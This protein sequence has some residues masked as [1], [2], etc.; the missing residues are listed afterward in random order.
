[1]E[2]SAPMQFGDQRLP[3][4]FWDKTQPEYNSGCW[5]W[6]GEQTRQGYGRFR[7]RRSHRLALEAALGRPLGELWALHS[8]DNPTCVNPAHLRP[9]TPADNCDDMWER[10]RQGGVSGRNHAKSHCAYGH[11]FTPENTRTTGGGLWRQCRECQRRQ[12]RENNPKWRERRRQALGKTKRPNKLPNHCYRGH[13][14]TPENTIRA[15]KARTCR[16]CA[17]VRDSAKQ[18]RYAAA[19]RAAKNQEQDHVQH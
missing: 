10:D 3:A 1:M 14:Y 17:A 5:L 7:R 8:C 16:I 11:E 13:E 2:M 9:G 4:P 15:G 12:G 6:L 19:R 18:K